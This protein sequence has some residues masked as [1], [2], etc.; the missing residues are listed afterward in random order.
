[1]RT[2][3]IT[4]L[5]VLAPVPVVAQ[6]WQVAR[7]NFGFATS[8]LTIHVDAEVAG[9]LRLIRGGYGNV[10]VASRTDRGFTT[11]GLAEGR[12]LTLTA[13]GPGAVDYLVAVPQD[14]WVRVRL[15]GTHFT[16]SVPRHARS[17]SFEWPAVSRVVHSAVDEW[18]PPLEEDG[19]LFATFSR[20]LAPAVVS[21]PDLAHV[22]SLT[23][24][25]E[26]GPFRTLTSRPLAVEEG[27]PNRLEIRPAAPAMDIVLTVPTGT[28]GFRLDAGGSTALLI[29]GDS[30]TALCSPLTRQRL[31]NGHQWLTF[32][33]MDGA[34]EC[35]AASTPRHEG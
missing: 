10:S 16:H 5:A 27:D 1:M 23:V 2:A 26:D 9:T 21:L 24:R 7:Q 19:S 28:R 31:S 25:I 17:H 20:D 8:R 30:V 18:L 4:L 32:N 12:E 11:A 33:P 3:L 34:L 13:T 29:D 14:V 35:T 6:E 22:R 15:P